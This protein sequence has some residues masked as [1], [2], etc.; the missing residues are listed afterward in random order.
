MI[1]PSSRI[2]LAGREFASRK[3]RGRKSFVVNGVGTGAGDA[4]L[5][6]VKASAARRVN[7]KIMMSAQ[8]DKK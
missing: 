5:Q 1:T 4:L 6:P 3:N 8:S 7:R 2:P